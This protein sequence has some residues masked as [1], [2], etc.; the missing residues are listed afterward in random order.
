MTGL[1]LGALSVLKNIA[2][3]ML[4]K[5]FLEWLLFWAAGMIVEST[6]TT[7]DNEFLKKLKEVYE[8]GDGK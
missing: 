6:K 8:Q 7:K 1:F 3:K 5:A 2:L 4:S